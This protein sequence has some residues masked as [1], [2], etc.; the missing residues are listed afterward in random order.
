M[1]A[2]VEQYLP[3]ELSEDDAI[4]HVARSGTTTVRR[5]RAEVCAS[6]GTVMPTAIAALFDH[7]TDEI[8]AVE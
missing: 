1:L 8:L 5:H 6:T 4:E 3:P 2:G 7:D